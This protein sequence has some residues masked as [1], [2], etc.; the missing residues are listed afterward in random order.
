MVNDLLELPPQA[1]PATGGRIPQNVIGQRARFLVAGLC[2]VFAL[3]TAVVPVGRAFL[4]LQ[5]TYNEGWNVYNAAIIAN[6]GTLYP[7]AYG[8]T[9]VNYP[10]LSF[11]VIAGLGR[12][13][14]DF[15][16]TARALS[17]LST[18]LCSLFVGLI[19]WRLAPKFLPAALAS[20]YCFAFF[21]AVAERY[22][23]LDDPQMFAQVFL[24]AGLFVYVC[25]RGRLGALIA[26]ALLL[27]IGANIK[28]I[29]IEFP[30]AILL[31]L[32]FISRRRALQFCLI[33]GALAALS[34]VLNIHFGGP[35]FLPAIFAAREYSFAHLVDTL[36]DV[37]QPMVVPSVL[38]LG[39]A[40]V[41]RT[42][43][44]RRIVSLLFG[45]SVLTAVAFGG[46]SGV[47]MNVLF[48]GIL[49]QA[50][51]L[52]FFFGD[53][54]NW[55]ERPS[56]LALAAPTLVFVW[57]VI[58]L[59]LSGN[60]RP[61]RAMSEARAEQQRFQEET[62]I[63]TAQPGPALCESLLRCYYA[64]KPYVYDPFNATRM[65]RLGKLDAQVM[66]AKIQR[67]EFGAIQ[68]DRPLQRETGYPGRSRFAPDI[69]RA[70]EQNYLPVAENEDGVIYTPNLG[71]S[72]SS[73]AQG[74]AALITPS[75]QAQ[76]IPKP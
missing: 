41:Y 34:V 33:G 8:W 72:A 68:L 66:A 38:A 53:F 70:I 16:F 40:I 61:L 21:C 36:A 67:Q 17:V 56:W 29:L 6:H 35:G 69:L 9:S 57:L 4:R 74:A 64:H 59:G 23:G 76:A 15:L 48:G 62:D 45:C 51:L 43:P 2:I 28:H 73:R 13:T 63:L 71:L 42:H 25:Y 10:A 44:E 47:W 50:M 19:V 37:Y 32:L 24:L 1:I 75:D 55:V 7:T 22:V 65:I 11:Y 60:W 52:G 39:L 5:V 54:P 58:P 3:Y 26:V 18:V 14:H 20:A 27:T 31:D 49:A 46:G 12:F 30:L